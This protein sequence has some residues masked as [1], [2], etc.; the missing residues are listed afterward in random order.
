MKLNKIIFLSS[1]VA[2]V[3]SSMTSCKDDDIFTVDGQQAF[4]ICTNKVDCPY[5]EYVD[6]KSPESTT[7]LGCT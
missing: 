1:A 3:A 2:A 6:S 5:V 7:L 4:I